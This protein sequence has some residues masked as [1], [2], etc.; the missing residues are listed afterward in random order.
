[1]TTRLL[2][3]SRDVGWALRLAARWA[4]GCATQVVLMDGAVAAARAGHRDHAAVIAAAEAGAVIAVHE[5]AAARRAMA[6]GQL[7]DGVKVVDLDEIADLVGDAT[8]Q[9]MWL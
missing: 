9:V 6:A 7:P 3:V 4:T 8:G 5:A 2:L 1:M